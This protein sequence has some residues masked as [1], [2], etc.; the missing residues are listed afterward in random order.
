MGAALSSK[1]ARSATDQAAAIGVAA[2]NVEE[3]LL[4]SIGAAGPVE[5]HFSP[6]ADVAQAGVLCALPA[7]VSCGLLHSANDHLALPKG[8]YGLP[9]IVMLLAFLA[10]ARVR[11]LESLRYHA[12]GE[13]GK[14]LGLDRI[15]E[16]RTLREKVAALSTGDRVEHWQAALSQ[17]WM[18]SNAES[19]GTLY[20]D[21]H[22]RV[23]HGSQ[24]QLP[25]RYVARQRLCLRGTTDYWVNAFDG[26]PFFVVSKEVDPGMLQVIETDLVPRLE[27]EVPG[28]PSAEELAADPFKARFTMV[29]DRAGYSPPFFKRM[30]SKRIAC[31]SYHKHPQEDWPPEQFHSCPVPLA[32]GEVVE[33]QLAERGIDLS[34]VLWLREIRKLT[35]GGHQ[36]SILSTDYC[37][38]MAP[39]A[40]ALFARWSQENFFRYMMEHYALDRIIAY[41]TE[42]IP[43]LTRVV[44]PAY[45]ELDGQ[46]RSTRG[47]LSRR[48]AEFGALSLEQPIETR[49]VE[50]WEQKK[51]ALQEPIVELQALIEQLKH[52]RKE[53]A[54]HVEFKELPPPSRFQRLSRHSKQFIDTIKM[55]AY[56]AETAMLHVL[57]DKMARHD[58]ARRLLC[59]IYRN[60]ADLIPNPVAGTLRVRLH[61]L[62][63]RITDAALY[64]LCDQL[65]ATE[66]LFPGTHLRLVY[67]LVSP[68]NPRD[69]EV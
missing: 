13:W 68:Q 21:G 47:Q 51:A 27:R 7:L 16:V 9:S 11:S 56:R 25:R 62:A 24:T 31:L 48:M 14:I 61:H 55:I 4:A 28:Q 29:F 58:D 5:P 22:V 20:V 40:G 35:E 67:E 23:Y 1:S 15:P 6:A 37:R 18:E 49:A 65:N 36:V 33:M 50:R 17:Q 66:T 44:N 38:P 63:N 30:W 3:R 19:A 53:V 41:C 52:H 10:L 43:D 45:R 54:R 59:A 46:L 39:L 32:S 60:D 8:Y 26:Q 42:P 64:H 12:P 57:R 69:Q 2:H 34:G